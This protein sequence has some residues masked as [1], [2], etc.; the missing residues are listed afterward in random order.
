MPKSPA[1]RRAAWRA[2][3]AK[4]KQKIG[5]QM[6]GVFRIANRAPVP[7]SEAA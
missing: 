3:K 1:M 2:T 5:A 7:E 4:V 6:R